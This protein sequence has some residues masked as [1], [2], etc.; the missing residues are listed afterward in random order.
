MPRNLSIIF[1]AALVLGPAAAESLTTP[2]VPPLEVGG[3]V[4]FGVKADRESFSFP[5]DYSSRSLGDRSRLMFDLFSNADRHGLGELYLKGAAVW[6][7]PRGE[8]R[9][10]RFVFEQADYFLS[11]ARSQLRVFVN[12]RRYFTGEPSSPLLDDDLVARRASRDGALPR[13]EPNYGLRLDRDFGESLHA[14]A[15]WSALGDAWEDARKFTYLRVGWWGRFYQLS[16]AYLL[17]SSEP[18]S[19]NNHA[20]VKSEASLF[21]K[22]LSAVLSY[23]QSGFSD[24]TAFFP[25]GRADWGGFDGGNLRATLPPQGAAF[26]E[27]RAAEIPV[28]KK[29]EVTAVHRY[30][31]LGSEFVNDLGTLR[32]DDVTQSSGLYFSARDVALDGRLVY[33]K[34]SQT[35]TSSQT[36]QSNLP[37]GENERLE[38]SVRG[39]LNNG[40]E[41]FLRAALTET[42]EKER[43]TTKENFVYGALRRTG[44]KIESGFH[45]MALDIDQA[46][47]RRRFALE[48][49]MNLT[50]E[51]AAYGRVVIDDAE[52]NWDAL[53]LR[54]ELRP[55]GHVF[56]TLEYGRDFVGDG[57]FLLEDP[58]IGRSGGADAVYALTLR[59]DF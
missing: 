30:R 40:S 15:I 17:D 25:S 21:Y 38:A 12:E 13:A 39:F 53:Y 22:K 27:F 42:R 31:T 10:A 37:A 47:W 48:T 54:L 55:T 4:E 45:V 23:T 29:V 19:L 41:L 35:A 8:T 43:A 33:S 20:L 49:R 34:S 5:W 52:N 24:K 6:A 56:A 2:D 36:M 14:C 51:I 46:Q 32:R 16:A 26:A 58:D 9:D 1:A 7:A 59:G 11:R 18:D 44:R 57:P 28:G 3:R 50:T